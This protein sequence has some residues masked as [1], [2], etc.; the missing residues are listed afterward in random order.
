[1]SDTASYVHHLED[2]TDYERFFHT[3]SYIGSKS[4]VYKDEKILMKLLSYHNLNR[5]HIH[6]NTWDAFELPIPIRYLKEIGVDLNTLRF[7][8]E[9]DQEEYEKALSL[10]FFPTKAVIQDSEASFSIIILPI[11]ICEI[12]AI[13]FLRK[14][15]LNM[16]ISCFLTLENIKT[17]YFK[18][19]GK[20]FANY[21][22]PIVQ[23]SEELVIPFRGSTSEEMITIKSEE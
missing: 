11:G 8:I 3:R 22:K 13:Y 17:L 4:K 12:G 7:T 2:V 19:D 14:M 21:Y 10:P 20:V 5:L 23:I 9:L 16:N 6:R 1:M 15:S 18:P